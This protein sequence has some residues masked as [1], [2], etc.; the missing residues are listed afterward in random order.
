MVLLRVLM[1]LAVIGSSGFP[2]AATADGVDRTELQT[3]SGTISALTRQDHKLAVET[4][5]GVVILAVDRNTTVFLEGRL[6][7]LFD[8]AVGMPVRTSFGSDLLAIWVE[9]VDRSIERAGGADSPPQVTMPESPK[10]DGGGAP[11][12]GPSAPSSQQAGL[13]PKDR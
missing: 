10:M 4:S 2:A 11:Q 5:R 7:T 8:L 1:L 13:S 6:G 9:V 3:V 12:A